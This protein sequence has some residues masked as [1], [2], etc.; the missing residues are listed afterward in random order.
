VGQFWGLAVHPLR[1][2]VIRAHKTFY[3]LIF[4]LFFDHSSLYV[5]THLLIFFGP[6]CFNLVRYLWIGQNS[7]YM[8]YTK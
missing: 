5:C 4:V 8:E 6:N 7:P 1:D 3:L 2:E